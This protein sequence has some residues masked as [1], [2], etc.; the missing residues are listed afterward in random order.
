M[1][2]KVL[3]KEQ[4]KKLILLNRRLL[5][6]IGNVFNL[7]KLLILIVNGISECFLQTLEKYS[8][9]IFPQDRLM[10]AQLLHKVFER[11]NKILNQVG[12]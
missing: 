5:R 9:R 7:H 12:K 1:D 11:E 2:T 10:Q 6:D 3:V 8:S 4:R